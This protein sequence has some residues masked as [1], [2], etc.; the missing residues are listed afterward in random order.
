LAMTNIGVNDALAVKLWS[1]VLDHEALK[2]TDIAPLIGDDPNS[3]IH[4]KSETSKGP[5][6]QIT[7]GIRMQLVGAGFT[8]NQLA[9]GNGESLTTYSDK[10]VINEL[11]HVVGVKSENSID[12]Q[13][14]PFSLR[15]EA[16][17]GL[18]DW[19]A[20]RYSVA[21]FN[22]VC[23]NTLAT[24]VRFTG[25]N[26]VTAATRIIRQSGRASD[27]LLV[28]GD[29]FTLDLIDKAKEMAIT[30][31]PK[32]RPAKFGPNTGLQG[33]G[34]SGR[35]DYNATLTDNY[36]MYINP[37]QVTDMRRNTSTGQWL[38]IEKA[39]TTG[40][41][42][43]KNMIYSG[44]IGEY[45]SVI[46]RSS[47]DLPSGISAGG[48]LVPNTARAVLLGGQAAMIAF[49][50]KTT[51]PSNYRWNEELFDHKRRLE[52]S[53]WTIHGLKKTTYNNLDY[54][55]VVVSTYAAAHT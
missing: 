42:R 40:L 50:R 46:L 47:F 5:G 34:S 36:V 24:D 9:E 25:L 53:A 12:Q 32:I 37:Y 39:A 17:G 18:A 54:G 6:D 33:M 30:A 7:Y 19:Y 3:I 21:F 13:R 51:G 22:Q 10:L 20:K 31:T 28:P 43:T 49:G 27:D 2:Y 44:A 35:R 4:R 55:T 48:V 1:K 8:E 29:T 45:N 14:V 15:D 16:K 38:D 23:G 26:P 11:G 41:G 52:V